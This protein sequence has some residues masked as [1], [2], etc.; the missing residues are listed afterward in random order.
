MSSMIRSK[1]VTLIQPW[2]ESEADLELKLGFLRSHGTTKNLKLNVSLLNNS[3]CICFEQVSISD[4]KFRFSPWSFPAFTLEFSGVYVKLRANKVIKKSEKRKEILSVLD[5]EGVLLHDAIEKIITNSITSARSWVMTSL[6][7]LLLVHCNLLIH[8]VNLELQLHD[9]DVSSSLKIKE[10]SLN[11]VDE[12]SCL[13]KGFVG[14]VLMPRRFCSLDFSVRG[15]EIGLRK[16]EYANRVLYLEEISTCVKLK[17]L[18][19]LDLDVCVPQFDIAFCPSDLQIVIA[20]DILI[21]KEAKHVRNGRELWNIAANRVDS[22][23]MTAKLSLRKLVGIARIWLRY[24]HTYESLLSLLGYPGETMFEKSSSR[25]SMNKKLSNDVR[26]HWKVVSEIEKDMPVEVLARGRRVARE[27]ASFQSST[28]S[29]TQRHVKF[30]KFIFSKILSYIARTF[31]F[32]YHSVIQFLVVWASLNRHEEVD[33]ISRVVSED[34]FHCCVNFRKVFITVNPVSALCRRIGQTSES[35]FDMSHL[36]LI[37]F[38]VTLDAFFL[39]YT[40]GRIGHTL[41]LSCGDFKVNSSLIVPFLE[42]SLRKET[43][44]SFTRKSKERHVDSKVIVWAEPA[45]KSLPVK[46][47]VTD[48]D[49]SVRNTCFLCLGSCLEELWLN[50]KSIRKRLERNSDQYLE[51]P[52][53]LFE[54]KSFLMDQCLG[55]ADVGLWKCNLSMGRLYADLGHSSIVSIVLLLRQIQHFSHGVASYE[56][57]PGLSESSTF[58]KEPEEIKWEVCQKSYESAVK[59]ALLRMIPER[60][61][62]IGIAIVGPQIRLSL[63][64]GSHHTKEQH[65]NHIVAQGHGDFYVVFNLDNIELSVWPTSK[66]CLA[67]PSEDIDEV[68]KKL[69]GSNEPQLLNNMGKGVN[70]NYIYQGCMALD[71]SVLINGLTVFLEDLEENQQYQLIGLKSVL[72]HSMACREYTHSFTTSFTHL[73]TSVRGMATGAVVLSYLDELQIFIQVVECILSALS[74]AFTSIDHLITDVYPEYATGEIVSSSGKDPDV[75]RQDYEKIAFL[76][77]KCTRFVIDASFEFGPLDIIMDNSRKANVVELYK[78]GKGTSSTNMLIGHD[79]PENGI[80]VAVQNPR[81]QIF[82]KEG[83]LKASISLSGLQFCISHYQ[84]EMGEHHDIYELINVLHQPPSCLDE[85]YLSN[86]SIT[87]SASSSD[88][89]NSSTSGSNTSD[90]TEGPLTIFREGSDIHSCD[91]NEKVRSVASNIP[92]PPSGHQL[93]INVALGN[94]LMAD[95]SLKNVLIRAHQ[96]TKLL[97][98]LCIGR[99]HHSISWT[100]QGGLI[101]LEMAAVA[102]FIHHFSAYILWIRNASSILPTGEYVS[103]GRHSEAVDPFKNMVRRSNHPSNDCL[104]WSTPSLSHIGTCNT[105]SPSKWQLLEALRLTLSQLSLILVVADGCGGVWEFM[106]EADLQLNFELMSLRRKLLFDLNRLTILSQHLHESCPDHMKEIQV[107]HF[108]PVLD[109]ELS[110]S[111]ISG[112][113]FLGLQLAERVL[114][115]ACSSS[116]PVPQKECKEE[117]DVTGHS[118]FSQ[119]NYILKHAAASILVEKAASTNDVRRLWMNID[120]IGSGS[121]SGLDLTISLS[122]IQMLLSLIQPLSGNLSGETSRPS[123]QRH[124]LRDQGQGNVFEDTIPDGAVVAIQDIHQHTYFA[125]EGVA[126]KYTVIGANH[127]SLVGERALF[128]VKYLKKRWGSSVSW[129]TIISLHAKSDSGAPLCLNHHSGSDFVDISSTGDNSCALWRTLACKHESNGADDDFECYRHSSESTFYLVNKKCDCGVAFIDGVPEFVKKPGN[130]FKVKL[131]PNFS[132]IHDVLRLD[133]RLEGSYYPDVQNPVQEDVDLTSE[134]ASNLP[135]VNISFEKVTL[136]I[137]HKLPDS[138]DKFPLLQACIDDIELIVQVLSSKARL[139]ST[140]AAA[141]YYYD[142]QGSLW[143]ELV[144]PVEMYIFYHFR[145]EY[146]SSVTVSK[147]VPVHLYFRVK[148]VDVSLNELSLDVLLFV[149]GKLGIAGPFAIRSSSI[150][151]NCCK[152]ENQSSL[153]LLCCFSDHQNATVAGKQSTSIF[154]SPV[155]S[156]NHLENSP[157]LSVQLVALG[158]FTTSPIRISLLNAQAKVSLADSRTSPGPFVVVDVSRKTEDGLSVVVSPLLRIH[159]E[160]G[161]SMEIRFWRPQR[162]EAE[163]ASV[164][165]R[166]GDTIDDSMAALDAINLYGGS[167]KALMSF[168]LGNF[169]LSCR[170]QITEYSGNLGEPISAQWSEDLKGGKAVCLSGIFDKLSYRFRRALSV[171]S[172]KYSFSTVH[173]PL[174]V[175][176]AHYTDLHFLVQSIGKDVPVVPSD[177]FRGSPETRT[178]PVAL[179]EQ[180]EIFFLPTVQVSNHLQS[181]IHVLLTETRPGDGSNCFGTVLV[182]YCFAYNLV[183]SADLS[184]ADGCSNIGKEATIACGSSVFLYANPAMIYFTVTL[185][186]FHSSCKAVNSGDW[187]KK[188]QKKGSVNYLDI[189]LDFGGGKYFASLRLSRGER[190]ILEAAISTSYILQNDSDL[191]LLCYASDQKPPSRLET[192]KFGSCLSPDL[193]LLLPPKS[194][195]SWFGKS[196]RISLKLLEEKASVALLDLD[197]LSGFT[198]VCLEK[199]VE[200]GVAHI[201]KFGVSLKPWH[202]EMSIPSQM[203]IIVPRYVILNETEHTIFVRQCYLEGDIDDTVAVDGKRKEALQMK[204]VSSSR[205]ETSL[206]DSLFRKHRIA[207]EDYLIYVQFRLHDVRWSWSGPICVASLGR[208]FLKFRRQSDSLGHQSSPTNEPESRLTEFAVVHVVEEGSALVMRFERPTNLRLP[209]RIENTLP[210]ASITFYQKDSV[211]PEVLRSGS[212]VSYVWDDLTLPHQLVVQITDLNISREINID[213]VRKWKPFFKVRQQRG[214]ALDLPLDKKPRDQKKSKDESHG[215]EMLKVGYE[216]YADGPTRVLRISEFP[217][218]GKEDAMFHLCAKIQF[219]VSLIAIHLLENIKKEE[220]VSEP[221]SH[222]PVV[223]AR[224]GNIILDSMFT[225]Q[226]KYNEIKVQSINVDE[227]WVGAPFAAL[228]RRNESDYSDTNENILQL[229]FVL[230]STDSGVIKVKHSSILLQPI[231]LNLDEETLIRLVPFWR[232]SLSDPYARSQ[233]FYFEHFEIHPIKVVASFLPGNSESSY[234]SAQETVR[235]FLHSVIKIPAVKNKKV[236]LNGILLTHAL[237]TVRELFIKSAQHYSWYA[238]RAVYIAKGSPLLPPAFASLFDDSASSSLDIFFDPSTG[239][240]NLPGIT[241]GMFKFVSKCIDKKGF[242]GTKRYFGDLGKSIKTAGSN[243]AFAAVTEIS[244]CVLKGAEANGFNGMVNGFHH[245]ILKLAMEP[246]LLG[247]AVMEGGPDRK[248]KLD[249]NPGVDELYIEGYLQAMLDTIYKQEYLRVRVVDDQVILKNLP[250]NSSLMNE[251]LDR[252]RSFLLSRGLLQGEPSTA[253]RPLRHLRGEKEWKIGPTVLTLW[254]HLFVSF[255]IRMLRKQV[256][257]LMANAK[258]KKNSGGDSEKGIV[259]VTTSGKQ[260]IKVNIKWGVRKFIFSGVVAYLDGRLCRCIPNT[261]VRRIVSG[262]LLSLLDDESSK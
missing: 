225:D 168:I 194:K 183:F 30:D 64:N 103:S 180:R 181:E 203:V 87:I 223:V 238:M 86:C 9:D 253:S 197:V 47:A 251:I 29:S 55:R 191:A 163:S 116:S 185:T 199:H 4:V 20:F 24:V 84:N 131:F 68:G 248:I 19:V 129:F 88:A 8:D 204:T 100:I 152:I 80:V 78:K 83:H 153:S 156:A 177:D 159:N 259:P 166:S 123:E 220:D 119:E 107:S 215:L 120:W 114:N 245:G 229:V 160:T 121:V 161:F 140:L 126:N 14:A 79:V 94:L 36:N 39:I 217:G 54:L 45:L 190:G 244:D 260:R 258:W 158:E 32:I 2:L 75:L 233:Q 18:R 108:S 237:V 208:F 210:N 198:E 169:L 226:N 82:W 26:N 1:L 178:T 97:S 50:W 212:S 162:K 256:T 17:D 142:A 109:N 66:A 104:L 6:L 164:L 255:S 62:Q 16:E 222:S 176:G 157:F 13:L 70:E 53:L 23:T 174:N 117:N 57:M 96:E 234:S 60:E 247:T 167:K 43:K 214:L 102:K 172:V 221:S 182:K 73:S 155:P 91:S 15:L 74:H 249:R 106:F 38:C 118:H 10:L 98:S 128:R 149:V 216:V 95:Y 133:T 218:R 224:F 41:S 69:F 42:R 11:A 196:N 202:F 59:M 135:Y 211:D 67:S 236:E 138:N 40:A 61:V 227:K 99:E 122:E 147:G 235:S 113:T 22:L 239:S 76:I 111:T 205:R 139:I 250:P 231:Q 34:Y 230:L 254:E 5:P 51:N 150:F 148:Q 241:L 3:S 110:S 48:S 65:V 7:N 170:P 35:P 144:H 201:L 261:V 219:R 257:K 56:R 206:F 141:M 21:A 49:N 242:S 240:V 143:R 12:C 209:Y 262:F 28:P 137:I 127:Y 243:V 31:C 195:R 33:G 89:I 92:P 85:F 93:L 145:F 27:R 154:M 186:E 151:T 175:E 179:Q 52:F 112:D 58:I 213:K 71:S 207:S 252:V 81:G 125:V 188:L 77:L 184:I 189:H 200:D 130:S 193:G 25:M 90:G 72:I 134:Q 136:T 124:W 101:I 171:E 146:P 46:K 173:C 105:Q 44:Q 37:S 228:L 192:D 246:S 232:T 132:F 187:V 115:D 63:Q 165:L